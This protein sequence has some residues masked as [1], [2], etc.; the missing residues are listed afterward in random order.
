M[1]VFVEETR[2]PYTKRETAVPAMPTIKRI[3]RSPL[4]MVHYT[5]SLETDRPQT[6]S[7]GRRENCRVPR[8]G[9]FRFSDSATLEQPISNFVLPLC[10]FVR[11]SPRN[12]SLNGLSLAIVENSREP[13]RK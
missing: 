2:P 12:T 4:F 6:S 13:R 8:G 7:A 3:S 5:T 1:H 11:P 10:I 9:C